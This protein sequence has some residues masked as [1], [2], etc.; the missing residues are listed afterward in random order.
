MVNRVLTVVTFAAIYL[1]LV[2]VMHLNLILSRTTAA[3]G[4]MGSHHY[5]DTFLRTDLLPHHRITA[6]APG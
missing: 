6:W 4:D 5:I 2:K 1:V 3:G